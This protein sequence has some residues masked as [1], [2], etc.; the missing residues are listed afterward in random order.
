MNFRI[1]YF[2]I[3]KEALDIIPDSEILKEKQLEIEN[4]YPK[5]MLDV[6]SAYQTGGNPYK[7]Y[8]SSQSGEIESFIM[9]GVK[10]TNGMTFNA[11]INIFDDIS[12]AVYNLSCKYKTLEF[13]VCHVDGTDIGKETSLQIICDGVLKEEIILAPDMSPKKVIVNVEGV[14]QLKMQVSSSGNDGPVYGVGNPVLKS[15]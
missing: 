6:V 13:T 5:N 4:S 10:Y 9:G 3:N 15:Y 8:T 14:T 12:W 2:R 11:D 7:E 1:F